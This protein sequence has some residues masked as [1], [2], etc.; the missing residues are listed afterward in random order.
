[1][2]FNYIYNNYKT[3]IKMN[4]IFSAFYNKYKNKT[5]EISKNFSFFYFNFKNS[6]FF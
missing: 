2:L 3:Q 4:K 1:M 6:S 5:I